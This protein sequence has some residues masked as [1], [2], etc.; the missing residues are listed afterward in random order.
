MC[1]QIHNALLF[2]RIVENISDQ[3]SKISFGYREYCIA[4]LNVVKSQQFLKRTI[5]SLWEC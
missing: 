2:R 5:D 1:G 4:E 3:L